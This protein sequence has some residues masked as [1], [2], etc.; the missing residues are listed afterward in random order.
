M[1]VLHGPPSRLRD[2]V[3]SHLDV[4]LFIVQ[5]YT[6]ATSAQIR[7]CFRRMRMLI[8]RREAFRWLANGAAFAFCAF[9][10]VPKCRACLYGSYWVVCP[11]NTPNSNPQHVD[12]VDDGTCQHKCDKCG[13]QCFRG[14]NVT[15]RCPNGHD[16]EVDTSKCGDAC[17]GVNCGTCG[18][19]CRIG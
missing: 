5:R 14:A 11:N 2:T 1:A 4:D 10:M 18:A 17:T 3:E 13:A 6:L 7:D 19:N 12:R 16:G 8:R 15:L 9:G